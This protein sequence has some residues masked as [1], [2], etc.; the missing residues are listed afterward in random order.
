V[1]HTS[2]ALRVLAVIGALF[3]AY[4]AWGYVGWLFSD[5]PLQR[6]G[7]G[8]PEDV[9]SSVIGGEV[10][11]GIGALIWISYLVASTWRHRWPTWPLILSVSWVLVYWQ[12][13]LVNLSGRR[14]TYNPYFLSR[15]D[16]IPN[17]PF[18]GADKSMLDQPLLMEALVFMW[19]IPAVGMAIAW[20]LGKVSRWTSSAPLLIVVGCLVAALFETAFEFSG[21]SQQLLAWNLVPDRL[22]LRGGTVHQWPMTEFPLGFVW[23]MP[24]ILWHLRDRLKALNWLDPTQGP[25]TVQAVLIRILALTAIINIVFLAYNLTLA[26]VPATTTADFPTWLG[27]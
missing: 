22:S 16:W 15:G 12:E 26:L 6:N 3:V 11:I 21:V 23:A 19:M 7:D 17:L 20:L 4:Q 1:L 5:I 24:G 18:S 8:V 9:K 13:S 10:L 25:R 14:F 2:R 27:G